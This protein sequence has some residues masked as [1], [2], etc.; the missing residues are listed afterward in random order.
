M[1]ETSIVIR[2]ILGPIRGNISALTYA[3]DAAIDL[4]FVQNIPMDDIMVTK[5]I[6]PVV[7]E[8]LRNRNGSSPSIAAVSRRI[9]RLANQCWDALVARNLVEEYIG[10]P[11]KDISA[12]RDMIFYLAFYVYLD[13][14]F[15]IAI[16]EQPVLLF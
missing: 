3:V 9:E 16:R 7:A 10:A 11:I 5:D 6:Y 2:S 12:P 1:T 13:M 14:P 15:Y 8:M 4:M